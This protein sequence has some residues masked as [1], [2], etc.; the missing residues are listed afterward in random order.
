MKITFI[1]KDGSEKSCNFS[2]EDTILKVA[3]RNGIPIRSFCEGF[4][5]CGACHI[6]VENLIDKLPPISD[7]ENDALD[8]VSGITMNSRLACQVT[9]T[10]ELDGLRVRIA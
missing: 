3:E 4:G 8:R 2:E 7:K 1:L 6:I 5:V 10:K 9:L